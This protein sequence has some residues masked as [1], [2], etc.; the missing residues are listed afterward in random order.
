MPTQTPPRIIA[1]SILASDYGRFAEEA[2][3]GLEAGGDWLHVDLTYHTHANGRYLSTI[4]NRVSSGGSYLSYYGYTYHSGGKINRWTKILKNSASTS[5]Q[6]LY[7]HTYDDIYQATNVKK[8]SMW[9]VLEQESTYRYDAAGN[10]DKKTEGTASTTYSTINARNQIKTATGTEAGTFSYDDNGNMLYKIV[11]GDKTNYEWDAANRL[12]AVEVLTGTSPSTNDKRIEFQYNG[13]G[14][15]VQLHEKKY[16]SGSWQTVKRDYF[17]WAAAKI[18]QKRTTSTSYTKVTANYYG[19]GESRHG[20]TSSSQ[21]KN[22]FHT[23]DHLGSVSEMTDQNKVIKAAYRYSPWG[24]RSKKFGD[25]EGLDCEFGFT[26]HYYEPNSELHLTW[27]RGYDAGLG[28]WLSTDPIGENGGINLYGYVGNSPGIAVDPDG[29]EPQRVGGTNYNR[30]QQITRA[31][32]V[33]QAVRHKGKSYDN[34]CAAGAQHVAGGR[35]KDAPNTSDWERGSQV[36]S[37]TPQGTMI[38]KGWVKNSSKA[39]GYEYPN[40]NNVGNSNVSNHT[41]ILMRINKDGSLCIRHQYRD[42]RTGK[43]TAMHEAVISPEDAKNYYEVWTPVGVV[44]PSSKGRFG[45][46]I[47]R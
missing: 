41:V 24:E 19:N 46:P 39:R 11:N 6:K 21:K 20:G 43:G 12:V 33:D 7:D 17:I 27:F 3:R 8:R 47:G 25:S 14:K 35:G 1:P 36:S 9:G 32:A 38:A 15:R 34:Q 23:R 28:R 22:Y 40:Q 29:R 42:G 5:E 4:R 18:I 45:P 13:A 44:G 10:R 30:H 2:R 31:V 16:Q 37:N 26:G